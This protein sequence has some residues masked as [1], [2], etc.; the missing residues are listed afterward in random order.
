[1][2]PDIKLKFM[3]F[4]AFNDLLIQGWDNGEIRIFRIENP[5]RFLQIKN[6][7]ADVGSISAIRLNF[8][9]R[10]LLSAGKDGIVFSYVIDKYMILQESNFNPLAGVEGV[11]YMP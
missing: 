10:F 2:F 3:A 11:D 9:E 6:H 4:S 1:M 8:D 5:D 7:D